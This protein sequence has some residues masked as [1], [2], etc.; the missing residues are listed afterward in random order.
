MP[1]LIVYAGPDG[2]G[3]STI[4]DLA[5]DPIDVTIDPDRIARELGAAG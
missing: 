1:R 3:K 2:S 5:G 4:R